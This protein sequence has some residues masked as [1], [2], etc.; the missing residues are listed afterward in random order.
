[1]SSVPPSW[2]VP[3]FWPEANVLAASRIASNGS[4][5]EKSPSSPLVAHPFCSLRDHA[6][7]FAGAMRHFLLALFC[8]YVIHGGTDPLH[9]YPAFGR[10]SSFK[11][12]WTIPIFARNII[13]TWLIA[14]GWDWFL[15]FS[16]W[17]KALSK[18]KMNHSYPSRSQFQH[19]AFY[20]T[21][22]SFIASCIEIAL[23]YCW[24]NQYMGFSIPRSSITLSVLVQAITLPYWRHPHFYF[25]HRLMHPWKLKIL[26]SSFD[27]GYYLYK[28]AHSLHHKSYNP[29][30]FS[31]TSMHPIEATLYYTAPLVPIIFFPSPIHPVISMT[32]IIDCGISAWLGHDGFQWPGSGDFYHLLHHQHYDCNYGTPHVPLDYWFGTFAACKGDVKKIKWDNSSEACAKKN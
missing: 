18:Y 8:M 19:D 2:F 24:A 15:Y 4:N 31:G 1:M 3:I 22:A 9:G 17:S 21:L 5:I 29:T 12:E 6:S 7:A 20:T 30:A 13:G 16:P 23:C 26:G 28:Y 14:G 11:Y 27:P 32:A 25:V 10:A